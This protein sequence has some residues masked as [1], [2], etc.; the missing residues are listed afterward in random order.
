MSSSNPLRQKRLLLA[1]ALGG[2]CVFGAGHARAA[3]TIVINNLNDPGVGFND[4]TEVEPVGG[5]AGTTLGQQRLN[6]FTYAANIWGA[7]LTSTQPVIINAQ[8]SSLSCNAGTGVLGSAGAT[9]IFRNFPNA[10]LPDTWYSYALAN[11]IAGAYQGAP[12]AAQI[13]A[14]FNVDLGKPG[15]IEGSSWY[16]GLDGNEGTTGIDFVAVLM[17]EMAHGLGFQTFTNGQSGA[18]NGNFPAVWDHFMF[19]ATAGKLW[20]D[21]NNAERAASAISG[22]KLVWVGANVTNAIPNVLR[23]GSLGGVVSGP[24]A[25]AAAGALP[26]GE[27]SFGPPLGSPALVGEIMPVTEASTTGVLG[28]GLACDPLSVTNARA[29]AGKVALVSRGVCAFTQKVKNAQNAGAV[30]VLVADNAPG[31]PPDGLG[32]ADPTVTIPSVRITQTDGLALQEALKRRS[33]TSSGVMVT[34]GL[35]PQYAGADTQ[36]RMKLYTPNPYRPGS[37]VSHYDS[38]ATRNQLMEPAI[39]ADLSQSVQPPEDLTLP[40][41]KDIGW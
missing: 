5:N 36:G 40:L 33:R 41:F 31:S 6:A 34:L 26:V 28:L 12:N 18:Q 4:T 15:C 3:L 38:S 10:P 32:G 7:N 23:F 21:M 16:Y 29:V 11:K 1:L 25:G 14:N 39:S 2:A 8:F 22:D 37:S 13:N 35:L 17:H 20:K 30:A 19:G 27:A 9:S 24:G